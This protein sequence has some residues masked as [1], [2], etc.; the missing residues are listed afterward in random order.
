MEKCSHIFKKN[1]FFDKAFLLSLSYSNEKLE[2]KTASKIKLKQAKHY[3]EKN[4]RI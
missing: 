3:Q 1:E 2:I 4:R